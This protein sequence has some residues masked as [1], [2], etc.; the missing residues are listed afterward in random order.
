MSQ[1]NN[2]NEYIASVDRAASVNYHLEFAKK[3]MNDPEITEVCVNRPFEVFCERQNVWERHDVPNLTPAHL[4]ALAT[5]VAKFASD[6]V[7][8][9]HPILSAILPGGER[10]Q[11]V[12]PP[13][14]EALGGARARCG[15]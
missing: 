7:S 6:D 1:R 14:C 5:A 3:W 4:L 2:S 8:E 10:V 11:I 12:L 9:N 13:A 15:D